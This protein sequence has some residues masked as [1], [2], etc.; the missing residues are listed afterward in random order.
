LNSHAVAR[1]AVLLVFAAACGCHAE[2]ASAPHSAPLERTL[3]GQVLLPEGAGSRGV[4]LLITVASPGGAPRVEWLLFDEQG[5]FHHT[6]HEQLIEVTLTA[7]SGGNVQ[8]LA[9]DQLPEVD[10]SGRIDVGV[11][12]L[13]DRLARHRLLLR[14][15]D[16]APGGD[17]RMAMWS[18]PPPVGPAGGRVELG[19]RQFP[20][21][22]L[23][24]EVEWLVPH[25]AHSIYFLVERPVEPGRGR[26][27]RSGHQRLFGP[28]TSAE[29]PAELVM[30]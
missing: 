15:A 24:G 6:L 8:R 27:W 23:G 2:P 30:D 21:V 17:V 16:G 22:A 29:L 10:R 9:S 12:D 25:G 14:A 11:I 20:P 19:S 18:G 26:A 13:R 28:F 5:R 3:V 7:G 1:L 4:E